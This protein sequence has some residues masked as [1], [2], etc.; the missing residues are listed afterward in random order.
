MKSRLNCTA[1]NSWFALLL[2][3]VGMQAHAAQV[4]GTVTDLSGPLLA[5]KSDGTVKVLAQKS[6]VEQGDLLVT[7]KDTYARIK[8]LD[9]SEVTLKPQTQFRIE[10]F[11]YEED[12]PQ[13]DNLFFSLL[14]GGLRAVSGTVGKRNRERTGLSTPAAT[15]GIRGTIY[16]A[17]YIAP[18]DA[19]VA[20]W[21]RTAIAAA[22]TGL[23]AYGR[24]GSG[25]AT[26]V[27]AATGSVLPEMLPARPAADLL[28]AQGV[29]PQGEGARAPG[30]YVQVLDGMIQLS[31]QGGAQNFAAGQFGYT[32]SMVRPPVVVPANPGIQFNP[33]PAFSSTSGTPGG[34]G[35]GR[36]GITEVNCEVR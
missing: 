29:M 7:E 11:S 1:I 21:G 27:D 32:A 17:E 15:I 35:G 20:A 31:N 24:G 3:L 16:V 23:Q 5:K 30:L 28:L 13:N 26:M 25:N 33:P 2:L 36:V 9:N 18:G 19:D 22:S 10:R 12:K 6:Q 34:S 14:R 4:A 8:F